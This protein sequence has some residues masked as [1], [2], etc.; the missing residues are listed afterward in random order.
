MTHSVY[1]TYLKVEPVERVET[2][3]RFCFGCFDSIKSLAGCK[4]K[5]EQE[6]HS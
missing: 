3:I 1:T 6:T 4:I 2:G 5:L